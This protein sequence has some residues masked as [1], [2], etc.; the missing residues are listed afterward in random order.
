[1]PTRKSPDP[2]AVEYWYYLADWLGLVE[3]RDLFSSANLAL[4]EDV[5]G[6]GAHLAVRLDVLKETFPDSYLRTLSGEDPGSNALFKRF[7]DACERLP[8]RGPETEWVDCSLEERDLKQGVRFC[9]A[10]AEWWR[11]NGQLCTTKKGEGRLRRKVL[12]VI[13]GE[14]RQMEIGYDRLAGLLKDRLDGY[15]DVGSLEGALKD[16]AKQL[17]EQ[18]GQQWLHETDKNLVSLLRAQE[19]YL[20]KG[21]VHLGW[22]R[23]GFPREG[24]RAKKYA[25]G[26]RM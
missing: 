9:V 17:D 5:A 11:V 15:K 6:V 23:G 16:A 3:T 24:V 1:M 8:L 12:S 20:P 4:L 7:R 13:V 22:I 26:Q 21:E 10:M 18:K 19:L 14:A 25:S 2:V